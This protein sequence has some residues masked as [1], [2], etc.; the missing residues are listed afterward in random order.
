[1]WP[2]LVR[3]ALSN[4]GGTVIGL[5]VGFVTMPLVVH[6]L[7]ATE[8]GLWVLATSLVGY[9]SVLDLGLSPTLVNAAA[10]LLA[11]DDQAARERLNETASTI[12]TTYA[13]LGVLG[14]AALVGVG[15]MAGALFQVAPDDLA[16][17]RAVLFVV[18]LQTAMN[19]P[20]S[21]WNGLLS[22]LQ[23]FHLTN[24]I[25]VA[26]TLVRGALTVTLVFAGYGVVA[27]VGASFVATLGAW[28]VAWWCVH[29]R[30]PG[31]RVGFGS[32]R[33]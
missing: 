6:H 29:R 15:T 11:R 27:I 32:S 18:G 14:G 19:L 16:T 31:L 1:M 10:A 3:N 24:A 17:F 7:G 22:G 20:M 30:I 33:C 23:A 21:V 5:V 13:V 26:L 12:F 9:L 2:K 4:V 8:F 28:A 25:G